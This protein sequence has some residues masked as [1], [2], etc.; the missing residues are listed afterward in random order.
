MFKKISVAAALACCAALSHAAYAD[1][2]IGGAIDGVARAGEDIADGAMDAGRDILNGFTARDT[3]GAGTG[4]A[5]PGDPANGTTGGTTGGTANGTTGGTTSDTT[6]GTTNGTTSGTTNGTSG[7]TSGE[8]ASGSNSST[9][10]AGNPNTGVSMGYV[11]SAAVLAAMG[12]VVTAVKRRD[13]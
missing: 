6:S 13:D 8:L 12:V 11:A 2:P 5:V 3:D 4:D 9:A 10:A 7:T 1:G